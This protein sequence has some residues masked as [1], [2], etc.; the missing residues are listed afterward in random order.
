MQQNVQYPFFLL[1]TLKTNVAEIQLD[2]FVISKHKMTEAEMLALNIK[3]KFLLYK[4][5]FIR[6][7]YFNLSKKT[8][9][10]VKNI[11]LAIEDLLV[12]K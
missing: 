2:K 5:L 3:N 6:G 9:L 11:I 1:N 10:K 7:W 4:I 12:K 8:L